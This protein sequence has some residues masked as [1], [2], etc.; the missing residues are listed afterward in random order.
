MSASYDDGGFDS[1]RN[2]VKPALLAVALTA[3]I[4]V[5]GIALGGLP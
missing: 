5:F 3:V 4:L 2:H 1:G